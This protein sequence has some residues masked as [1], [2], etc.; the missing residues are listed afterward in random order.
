MRDFDPGAPRPP[1]RRVSGKTRMAALQIGLFVVGMTVRVV[2]Y[3]RNNRNLLLTAALVPLAC[4]AISGFVTGV[5]A[6]ITCR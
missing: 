4:G 1:G 6:G 3:R 5:H 2:G